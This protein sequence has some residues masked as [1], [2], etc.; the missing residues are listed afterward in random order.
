MAKGTITMKRVKPLLN[1]FIDTN[2][3]LEEEGK[4]PNAIGFEGVA[5]IGKTSI[6]RE[7]ANERGMTFVKLNLA[8]IDEVGD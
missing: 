3:K 5:G 7:I 6:V 8:Q 2:I 4:L 1:H